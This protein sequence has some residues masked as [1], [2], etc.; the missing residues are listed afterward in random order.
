MTDVKKVG[1]VDLFSKF[2][3]T[4][5]EAWLSEVL[6]YLQV[7]RADAN[8]P[9][10]IQLVYEQWLFSDLSNSTRPKIRLPPF[11]K[12]ASLDS[13]VV[14]QINWLVDIHTSM[15]SKLN[16]VECKIDH[17]SFHW[18]PNDGT[19]DLD[20]T[21]R[22][23]LMEVTDGQRKMRAIEYEKID[24]L[25]GKLSHGTKLLI[26]AGTICRRNMLLL[27]PNNVMILGGESEICQQ[28]VSALIVAR[29]LGIDEKKLKLI[30]CVRSEEFGNSVETM[31]EI[32]T[33]RAEEV[34]TIMP[35]VLMRKNVVANLCEEQSKNTHT[36]ETVKGQ[37]AREK[38][39]KRPV[40]S[41]TITSYFQPQHKVHTSES[42]S[43]AAVKSQMPLV[44]QEI[45]E[46]P[47]PG[48]LPQDPLQKQR[49]EMQPPPILLPIA[50]SKQQ[51]QHPIATIV[52]PRESNEPSA[53]QLVPSR[54][55]RTQ[56]I[57]KDS[58]MQSEL[59]EIMGKSITS[60][61][62]QSQ[63]V[64]NCCSSHFKMQPEKA[65]LSAKL[66]TRN[67]ETTRP[68]VVE[69]SSSTHSARKINAVRN[70]VVLSGE[71]ERKETTN[72]PLIPIRS[73]EIQR[74]SADVILHSAI[75]SSSNFQEQTIWNA[76]KWQYATNEN[77]K[78]FLANEFHVPP[79]KVETQT[80]DDENALSAG[81]PSIHKTKS[82][83]QNSS[84][85][86]A[87]FDL[88]AERAVRGKCFKIIHYAS[89]VS[90]QPDMASF[91]SD[92]PA[93]GRSLCR[94]P[95]INPVQF[96]ASQKSFTNSELQKVT[97][98][99][100]H[101]NTSLR[102]H[103][104]SLVLPDTT[105]QIVPHISIVERY[106]ALNIV[107]IREAYYQRRYCLVAHRKTVQPIF[108][109]LH[110]GLQFIGQSWTAALRIADETCDAL[111]CLVDNGAI[112][113]LIGFT[114]QEAQQAAAS[115]DRVRV[116]YYKGRAQAMLE[117]FKRLDLVLTIEFSSSS[118][119]LPLIV[120]I[121]NLSTALGLC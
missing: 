55:L 39:Q 71:S 13:D 26:Y 86:Q 19:K 14:V 18:E 23:Y 98:Q 112:R 33:E 116:A 68:Q 8:I 115:N 56:K 105:L 63:N 90:F 29:R 5:K 80:K 44:G 120:D 25:C 69:D 77:S 88:H 4:L 85:K 102:N 31:E 10:V 84:I 73:M 11:E 110:A 38:R 113:N 22:M 87:S 108:C 52:F 99:S 32:E 41:R 96:H 79:S 106:R 62:C 117:I 119:V 7:E 3:V 16:H 67:F 93:S 92:K 24:E 6:K 75:I 82:P 111:D 74:N 15:Y 1:V 107:S 76:D 21:N 12:K 42:S 65:S 36:N 60:L 64:Q 101:R 20:P 114:P 54:A 100:M 48:Y 9:T 59:Q 97:E 104:T 30:E 45:K 51:S 83:R 2:H 35:S 78:Q 40:L 47:E 61:Q 91:R 50:D 118:D 37:N 28:N 66:W 57:M 95:V 53:E 94:P 72:K 81:S 46:E 89:N 27:A 121:T 58:G 17:S 49:G 70:T 109:K 103:A 43:K 34:R